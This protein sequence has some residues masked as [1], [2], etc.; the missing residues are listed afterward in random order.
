MFGNFTLSLQF[1]SVNARDSDNASGFITYVYSHI[2]KISNLNRL[3]VLWQP[4][5]SSSGKDSGEKLLLS[6]KREDLIRYC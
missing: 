1:Y 3:D 5:D 6:L 2:A 4:G